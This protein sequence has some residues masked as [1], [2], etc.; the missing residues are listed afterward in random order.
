VPLVDLASITRAR[1]ILDGIAFVTPLEYSRA[2]SDLVGGPVY[3]KCEN[4]QRTGSFKI[5]GAY[6]RM[7]LLSPQERQRGVVAASAGNHAQ[8]VALAAQLL[9]MSAVVYM[10]VDVALPK[11]E[12]TQNYGAEVRLWGSTVDE[13]LREARAVAAQTGRVLIHP[14]DHPDIV[15]GQGTIGPEILDSVPDVRT[16]LVPA[17]GGGLLAGVAHGLERPGDPVRVVGVQAAGAAAYPASLEA[18]R[19]VPLSR[20]NTIADGI[21]VGTPGDVPFSIVRDRVD[22][23]RTVSEEQIARGLLSIVERSK[24]VVEPS[25]A[26]GVAALLEAPTAFQAPVVI[27]LSGGNVD[28]LALLNVLRHGL[29]VAGRFLQ[30][31]VRIPDRPGSLATLLGHLAA[32]GANIVTVG[33]VRTGV[34]LLVGEVEIEAEIETKGPDHCGR[35]LERLANAGYDVRSP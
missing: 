26:V 12:A 20:M 7:S 34:E 32:T 6:V 23:I 29:S 30:L 11:L 1:R 15:A 17:G 5:R 21:A 22:E 18:G 35:V 19:P 10:P 33:H 25:A 3:L 14:F 31:R 8:G 27:V 13:A 9:G 24:L 16:V 28:T 4:L 2:L